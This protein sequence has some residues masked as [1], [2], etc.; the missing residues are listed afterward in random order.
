MN[1]FRK[2]IK[3]VPY[4]IV[5]LV[6]FGLSFLIDFDSARNSV[7]SIVGGPLF[8]ASRVEAQDGADEQDDEQGQL[9]NVVEL[10]DAGIANLDLEII[11]L[12]LGTF[13]KSIRMPGEI[14]EKPGS[15]RHE[16][17]A[18]FQSVVSRI[19][20]VQGQSIVAGQELFDLQV[21]D[22]AVIDAQIRLLEHVSQLTVVRS[23]LARLQP[24]VDSGAVPGKRTIELGNDEK[25]L[26]SQIGIRREELLVRGLSSEQVKT[27][28]STS[29][30]IRTIA[31]SHP[32]TGDASELFSLQHL[33]VYPGK[34]LQRGDQLCELAYHQSLYIRGNA[35]EHEIEHVGRVC[36][37]QSDIEVLYGENEDK[38]MHLKVDVIDNHVDDHTQ[39]YHFYTELRNKQLGEPRVD[40]QGRRFV[41]WSFKPGQRVHLKIPIDTYQDKLIVPSDAIVHEGAESYVFRFIHKHKKMLQSGEVEYHE[42]E[43]VPVHIVDRDEEWVVVHPE[44]LIQ[45]GD[46]VAANQAHQ[47]N[48]AMKNAA[49][50]GGG[51]G[52]SHGH[53]HGH[54]H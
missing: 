50:G 12:D 30:L 28:E 24:L 20:V 33:D 47:L 54:S 18:P 16:L 49:G 38:S 39:T 34:T 29:K 4:L 53:G 31:Y 3:F 5:L 40:E 10:S 22:Q 37:S 41:T 1:Q 42:F 15:S 26:L 11:K 27:I 2:L 6:G 44:K 23:E 13:T 8:G 9:E 21:T 35:F 51:H 19:H 32:G 48:L 46:E 7:R 25:Q 52:H 17:T 36:Q 45:V 43:K 14:I